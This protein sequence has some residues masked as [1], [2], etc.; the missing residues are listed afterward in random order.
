M[1]HD[2]VIAELIQLHQESSRRLT[3]MENVQAIVLPV[4]S[5]LG[6]AGLIALL[7]AFGVI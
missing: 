4:Y 7:K 3:I 6:A 2:E 1:Q 5:I